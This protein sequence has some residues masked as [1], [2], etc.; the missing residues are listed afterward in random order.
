MHSELKHRVKQANKVISILAKHGRRFFY[1]AVQDRIARFGL[2]RHEQIWY[3]DER[4]GM[5]LYPFGA[6]AWPG[7]T[8]AAALKELVAALALYIENGKTIELERWLDLQAAGYGA[9]A[10]IELR[11]TE[12]IGEADR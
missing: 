8:N 6:Q 11:E 9:E 12:A 10:L 7:F 3:V 1:C 4:S 2:D 5:K